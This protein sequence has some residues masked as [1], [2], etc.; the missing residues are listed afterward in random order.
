MIKDYCLWAKTQSDLLR[1]RDF[2]HLDIDNIIEE[3]ES[4]GNSEADKIESHLTNYLMHMLKKRYQPEMEHRS[5]DLSIKESLMRSK[6]VLIKN[7]SIKHKLNEIYEDAYA[8]A[9]LRAARETGLNEIV[10][11]IE[12]PW[13]VEELLK[14]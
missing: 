10:F 1:E 5:W 9:R 8:T 2:S 3:I 14:E 13:T 6:R 7:P 4:L 11:P 12:C